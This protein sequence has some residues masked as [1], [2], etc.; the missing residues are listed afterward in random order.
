LDCSG[1]GSRIIPVKKIM[2]KN[3]KSAD[4]VVRLLLVA[5]II[6]VLMTLFEFIKNLFLPTLSLWDSHVI[7]IIFI[8]VIGTVATYFILIKYFNLLAQLN[9]FHVERQQ[10]EQAL[11]HGY[12][13]LEDLVNKQSADLVKANEALRSEFLEHQHDALALRFN[14]AQSRV[15]ADEAHSI[16]L[17]LNLKGQVTFFNKF[18][19]NFFGYSEDEICGYSV[20]GTIVPETDTAGRNLALMI[21]DL[22]S[23]PE[24]YTINENENLK[25]NGERILVSWTN[26]A[27][28][29]DYGQVI[30]IVCIGNEK[31]AVQNEAEVR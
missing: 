2:E 7:T 25:R 4:L 22:I 13:Y 18:A 3:R 21:A 20:I 5:L 12:T 28:L 9:K 16:I 30:E 29:D 14:E 27:I 15:L 24:R 26:K 31:T 8:S 17:R 19:Q 1:Q 6:M 11:I 23:H 10:S